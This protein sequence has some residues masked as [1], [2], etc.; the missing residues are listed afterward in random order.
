[1]AELIKAGNRKDRRQWSERMVE[2]GTWKSI[3]SQ[4]HTVLC[5]RAGVQTHVSLL[6]E[7]TAAPKHHTKGS[8]RYIGSER[9]CCLCGIIRAQED[10][11]L[12]TDIYSPAQ[13]CSAKI[14]LLSLPPPPSYR[15][16]NKFRQAWL[17][18]QRTYVC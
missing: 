15:N 14:L 17:L 11:Q 4:G 10:P 2:V 18:P 7:P 16:S 1:M 3:V 13:D 5:C 12:S 6:P 8:E 9:Y